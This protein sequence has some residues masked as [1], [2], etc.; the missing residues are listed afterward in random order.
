MQLRSSRIVGTPY[1]DINLTNNNISINQLA[2]PLTRHV[3]FVFGS[4]AFTFTLIFVYTIYN[5]L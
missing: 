5:F 3:I 2:H 4:I 1:T